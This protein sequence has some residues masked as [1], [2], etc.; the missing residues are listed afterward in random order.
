MVRNK[1]IDIGKAQNGACI[2]HSPQR[3]KVGRISCGRLPSYPDDA[4]YANQQLRGL[5]EDIGPLGGGVSRNHKRN[6]KL[7]FADIRHFCAHKNRE[8]TLQLSLGY[9][10]GDVVG[11]V[12]IMLHECK[13]VL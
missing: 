4:H 10:I 1:N 7:C 6:R 11:L 9:A 3:K 8:A 12:P 2:G 5:S 13:V